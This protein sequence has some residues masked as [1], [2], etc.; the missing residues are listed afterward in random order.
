MTGPVVA[1]AL[2]F[3]SAVGEASTKP[4]SVEKVMSWSHL[5]TVYCSTRPVNVVAQTIVCVGL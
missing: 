2:E 4:Y 5:L 1:K 3:E